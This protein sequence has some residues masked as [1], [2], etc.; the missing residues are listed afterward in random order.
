MR[1]GGLH[2]K[3]REEDEDDRLGFEVGQQPVA[4]AGFTGAVPLVI[5][6]TPVI[7]GVNTLLPTGNLILNT[8]GTISSTAH[9]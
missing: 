5:S 9:T 7:A 8:S 2:R 4:A 3:E 1:L 6:G